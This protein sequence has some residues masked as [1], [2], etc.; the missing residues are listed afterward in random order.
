[1]AKGKP[2]PTAPSPIVLP[3][4]T[5]QFPFELDIAMS[6]GGSRNLQQS[7]NVGLLV[8]VQR[9]VNNFYWQQFARQLSNEF[10]SLSIQ[11]L[12]FQVVDDGFLVLYQ[13]TVQ[14]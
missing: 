9:I 4:V 3:P 13:M 12:N 1:M 5:F 10:R 2:K 14:V 11:T 6:A 8:S 7:G